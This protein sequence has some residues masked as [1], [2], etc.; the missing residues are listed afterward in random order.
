M[1]LVGP[2]R[3]LWRLRIV[4]AIIGVLAIAMGTLRRL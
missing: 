4:V 1:G 2:L 3:T